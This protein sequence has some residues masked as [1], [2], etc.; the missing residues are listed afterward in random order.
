MERLGSARRGVRL[1][2]VG[3]ALATLGAMAL[4]VAPALSAGG[5]PCTDTWNGGAHD[6]NWSSAGN[7]SAGVPTSTSDVCITSGGPVSFGKTGGLTATI[8]SLTVGSGQSLDI[9]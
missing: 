5:P 2:V 6:G 1:L 7:W 4:R 8:A 3:C 9:H